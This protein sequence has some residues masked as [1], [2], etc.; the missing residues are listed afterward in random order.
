MF[1]NIAYIVFSAMALIMLLDFIMPGTYYQEKIEHLKTERQQYYNAAQNSHTTTKVITKSHEFYITDS[2]VKHLEKHEYITYSVSKIFNEVN[3]YKAQFIQAK[4]H[5]SLRILSG[6]VLP[7][8]FLTVL[9]IKRYS[10][11]NLDLF[12]FVLHVV[13]LF[14]FIFLLR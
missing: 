10:K 11:R 2:D 9:L 4:S 12:L 1:K 3:W 7:I 6:V 14:N 13:L 5:Y 8:L